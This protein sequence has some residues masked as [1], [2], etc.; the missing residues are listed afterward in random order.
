[1]HKLQNAADACVVIVLF[2]L[3]NLQQGE[4]HVC[5][6]TPRETDLVMQLCVSCAAISI[7]SS[8]IIESAS[9]EINMQILCNYY[10]VLRRVWRS[11]ERED[12]S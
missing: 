4:E 1:M 3:Y 10:D 2:A 12:E 7:S 5:T 11:K 6:W 9:R 8:N